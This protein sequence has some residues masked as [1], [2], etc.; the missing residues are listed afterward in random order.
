MA[1]WTHKLL[2]PSLWL[3][4]LRSQ[5]SLMTLMST[6][7]S[8]YFRLVRSGSWTSATCLPDPGLIKAA[9]HEPRRR[10]GNEQVSALICPR[11]GEHPS[12][13]MRGDRQHRDW[14]FESEITLNQTKGKN[15]PLNYGWNAEEKKEKLCWDCLNCGQNIYKPDLENICLVAWISLLCRILKTILNSVPQNCNWEL[16]SSLNRLHD[17]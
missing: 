3:V 7:T 9:Q 6:N 5:R 13:N 16:A 1:V 17:S 11:R 8:S 12:A 4:T 14:P 10:V 15:S 2:N